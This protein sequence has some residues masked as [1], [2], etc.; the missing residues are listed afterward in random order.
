MADHPASPHPSGRHGLE[1]RVRRRRAFQHAVITCFLPNPRGSYGQGED[2]TRANVKDFGGGDLR[3]DLAGVDAAIR[4]HPIDPARLG[5]TGWS[6][7]GFMT[8][9]DCH[10]DRSFPRGR[11]RCRYR[12]LAEL[13]RPEPDRPMDDPVLRR[14]GL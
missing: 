4:K 10:A 2:F 9:C 11:R 5:V 3:D 13:L 8:M 7:G 1:C 6:Y 14:V 12:Q